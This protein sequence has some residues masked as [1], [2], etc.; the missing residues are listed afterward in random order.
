MVFVRSILTLQCCVVLSAV[1][2]E[3]Q[4]NPDTARSI[5]AFR[6][7]VPV[8]IDGIIDEDLWQRAGETHFIQRLPDE[9]APASQKTEAWVA[10]D[11]DALYVAVKL[12]DSRPDS[13]IGRL[14]RR[15][16]DS[17]SDE[18]GIE[19]DAAHDRRTAEYFIV[20]PVGAIKDGTFSNDTQTD[21]SWDGI[22]DVAVRKESW[23]WSAEF[24]IPFSQLRFP[25]S[26][27]YVWGIEI[28][29]GIKRRNE[30]SYLVL[31]PRT[32]RVRVSR[33]VQ[34]IGIERIKPPSRIELLPYATATG[35]FVQQQP[36][37]AFN[38][39]RTDPFKIQRKF[40]TN[41]G[42]DAKIGLAGDVTLDLSLN[43]DFAQVEVD[44]A[45]VNLTAYETYYQ[46]K[47]P[48][49]IE[50]SSIL[51]F[52][53]GGA[54]LLQDF[55]WTD[56]SFFYSRRIGRAPQGSVT[57]TGFLDLPDRTTILGAAKVSGKIT[58]SW[59][60]AAL[61]ALTDREYG[62]VDSA[63]IRFR[64]EIEPLAFY[65][66]VRSLKEFNDARQAIG[67]LGTIVQRNLRDDRMRGLVNDG[68]LSLGIDGWTFLDED[69]VWVITGWG[70]ASTVS[71]TRERI[72]DLQRSAQ[73]FFQR[74]DAG[75]LG[76]D[77][78]ATTLTG[79]ASRVWLDKVSGNWI[80][81]AA[82][83]AIHPKFE[84]VYEAVSNTR[85][86]RARPAPL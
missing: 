74:P 47:R 10:Y 72:T 52:G 32:D 39:G 54:S 85:P 16:Q 69:K 83:G 4:T 66:V 65:G 11:D 81:D 26:D 30:E 80:F 29:R 6:A 55:D 62:Q 86:R 24:R 31:H 71:G 40:P 34:L 35:K 63:G 79:W 64:D 20:N 27:R 21:D 19:I 51:N 14:A 13:I 36:V 28:Y 22:W 37:E 59:S 25:K 70:G 23:G 56:P 60:F 17:E 9:G 61:S 57:H 2:A 42:A 44:P 58:N 46:E 18:V 84:K 50:G 38:L 68:A 48:F 53:R 76:V 5:V 12:Y 73:H 33:W 8:K 49:F 1:V 45:V 15:D 75:Y 77:S 67:L 3:S 78:S 7:M 82:F 43:P 41:L